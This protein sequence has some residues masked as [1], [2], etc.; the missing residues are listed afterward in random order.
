M[1][2]SAKAFFEAC[3]T[4]KGWEG[5]KQYCTADAVFSAQSEPLAEIKTVQGYTDWMAGLA[6]TTM[7][8]CSYDL[9]HFSVDEASRSAVFFAVFIGTHTGPGPCEPTNKSTSSDY[10][11]HLGFD[12]TGKINSMTKIWNAP[13][14]MKQLGWM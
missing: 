4:G 8:G 2:A 6:N 11:Y 12:E 1:E 14:A 5:C 7:P 3:E 9:K 13:W 10:V